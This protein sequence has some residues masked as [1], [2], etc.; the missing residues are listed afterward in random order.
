MFAEAG[1]RGRSNAPED[2]VIVGDGLLARAAAFVDATG[3]RGRVLDVATPVRHRVEEIVAAIEAATGCTAQYRRVE[4]GDDEPTELGPML[5]VIGATSVR[6]D[7]DYLRRTVA[8]YHSTTL[9]LPPAT[10]ASP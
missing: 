10:G 1:L 6:F 2:A 9:N 8:R 4:R 7:E 3:M 5:S